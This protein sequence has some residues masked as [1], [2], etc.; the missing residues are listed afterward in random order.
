MKRENLKS[1]KTEIL[2]KDNKNVEE[3]QEPSKTRDT[4]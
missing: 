2:Y 4:D 3:S 1:E